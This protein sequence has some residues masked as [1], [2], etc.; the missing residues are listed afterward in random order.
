MIIN[1]HQNLYQIYDQIKCNLIKFE[2]VFEIKKIHNVL[3]ENY[4]T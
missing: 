2:I 1:R 4:N 3:I